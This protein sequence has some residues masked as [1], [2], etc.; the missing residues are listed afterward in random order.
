MTT[1]QAVIKRLLH[2][3]PG[4][5]PR[6][7]PDAFAVAATI[8]ESAGLY[9]A[10]RYA[11]GDGGLFGKRYLERVRDAGKMWGE[12]ID[13]PHEVEKAWK[14]LAQSS[15]DLS[16]LARTDQN[17]GAIADAAIFVLAAADEASAGMGFHPSEN[18]NF[19]AFLLKATSQMHRDKRLVHPHAP[20]SLCLSISPSHLCVQPKSRT[21]QVGCSLRSLTH[22]LALL[23]RSGVIRTTWN[24]SVSTE[25]KCDALNLLLVPFPYRIDSSA[26]VPGQSIDD[27]GSNSAHVAVKQTWCTAT[28]G[29]GVSARKLFAF[30]R[31][32]IEEAN[33]EAGP[34]HGVVLPELALP[35]S[36]AQTIGS[37]LMRVDG[38]ELFVT[39]ALV[40]G[41]PLP[42]NCAYAS[43]SY[44]DGD[45]VNWCQAKHHR[46][47]I[48][49]AQAKR[50][51]LGH[52]LPSAGKGRP[53]ARY[54]EGI[55][56]S[57][58]EL[59]TSYGPAPASRFLCVR[60]SRAS[61]RSSRPSAR[62]GQIWSSR[63][64]WTAHS[65]S[66]AGP[67]AMRPSSPTIPARPS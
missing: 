57:D 39:G 1:P 21:P 16:N 54:W 50:Y 28:K 18:Q 9:A 20:H 60:I 14:L 64:S 51:G 26:F 22:N 52:R 19:A 6:W 42:M 44:T 36:W 31:D 13:V 25:Q 3:A 15:D 56:I 61:N 4:G 35:H 41:K 34:V 10:A 33:R 59:H 24:M 48:D 47:L 30:I 65:W 5:C 38:I 53:P 46:W 2:P 58:R 12:E 23:P 67:A 55:D 45:F 37:Q 32:L 11:G 43:L 7:P 40:P 63:S 27:E 8:V 66:A 17:A 49:E 29:R 62:W